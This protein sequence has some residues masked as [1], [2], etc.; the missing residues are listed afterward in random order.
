MAPKTY[1]S[2]TGGHLVQ[3]RLDGGEPPVHQFAHVGMG[4]NIEFIVPDRGEHARGDIRRLY[5]GLDQ[6]SEFGDHC[7][8]RTGRIERHGLTISLRPIAFALAMAVRTKWG[9]STLTPM[10]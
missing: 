9:Q 2:L 6:P 7:R 3:R 10:P 5:P 8:H 4:E 1:L